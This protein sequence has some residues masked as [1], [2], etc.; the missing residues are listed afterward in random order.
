MPYPPYANI[1]SA[2]VTAREVDD[3]N[4]EE[5]ATEALNAQNCSEQLQQEAKSAETMS[6]GRPDVENEPSDQETE[7]QSAMDSDIVSKIESQAAKITM[8]LYPRTIVRRA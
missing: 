4:D 3:E 8:M 6:E 5:D 7:P 1:N 2:P